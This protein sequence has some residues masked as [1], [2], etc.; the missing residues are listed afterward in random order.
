MMFMN[1]TSRLS[2]RRTPRTPRTR[3]TV[4]SGKPW[5]KSTFGVSFEVTQ[6]S[7]LA[8]SIVTV[9]FPSRPMNRPTCTSTSVTA[10]ATPATVI[11]KRSPSWRRFLRASETTL[12]LGQE[13]AEA[14]LDDFVDERRRGRRRP[15][16]RLQRDQERHDAVQARPQDLRREIG[17]H[18]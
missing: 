6:M 12:C 14:V 4:V 17:I 5:A 16:L 13:A 1:W 9:D 11:A 10:N 3:S 15:V 18:L 7:A 8:C 2:A